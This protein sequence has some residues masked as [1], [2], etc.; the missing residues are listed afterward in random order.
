VRQYINRDER[1]IN[2]AFVR[3]LLAAGKIREHERKIL[4]FV[5]EAGYATPAQ[6]GRLFFHAYAHPENAAAQSMRD[7]YKDYLLDR[8]DG[9]TLEEFGLSNSVVYIVGKAG[10]KILS[11]DIDT[12]RWKKTGTLLL[13]H[14][15]L[16]AESVSLMAEHARMT[17]KT[18]NFYGERCA[19]R[20][21]EF[22]GNYVSMRP[23]AEVFIT[24]PE[25]GR[26]RPLSLEIDTTSRALNTFVGK[27]LQYE[28]FYRSAHW[29]N[30]YAR[31]PGVAVIVWA[32]SAASDP[33]RAAQNRIKN[34]RRRLDNTMRFVQSR[35][36]QPVTWFFATLRDVELDEW[37]VLNRKN[38]IVG[39]VSLF[40]LE[41]E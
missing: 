36:S 17:N 22:D 14:N 12:S 38:Q 27:V 16:L 31:F 4:L 11:E 1:R 13:N 9:D 28:A 19:S 7:M 41:A 35:K 6:I 18:L 15:I 24:Y 21:F 33:E 2:A 40:S 8:V 30:F 10:A 20:T 3:E 25:E 5:W 39:P 34:S 23:D 29:K 26:E 32:S 37:M